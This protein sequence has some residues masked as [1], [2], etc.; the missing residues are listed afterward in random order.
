MSKGGFIYVIG[1]TDRL[2]V[3]I[4]G[5]TASVE[6]R[7][8]QA[9]LGHPSRLHIITVTSVPED[10]L[11]V[12]KQVHKL[13]AEHKLGGEWFAISL[14]TEKLTA[15]VTTAQEMVK[16]RPKPQPTRIGNAFGQRICEVRIRRG[17]SQ[18][19]LATAAGCPYQVIS[20]VEQGLQSVSAERFAAIAQALTISSD[21][22]L[23]LGP[24]AVKESEEA[25]T[26]LTGSAA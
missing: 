23:G 19:A 22:L 14:D 10:V 3:K 8:K 17:L 25:A 5:T 11:R 2:E 16:A 1:P 18:K 7:L 21:Y 20:R 24:K 9:Q 4:G 12:E 6:S 15:L 26:A 13:L